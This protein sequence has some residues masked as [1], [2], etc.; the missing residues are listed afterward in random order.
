MSNAVGRPFQAVSTGLERPSSLAHF[1]A[2]TVKRSAKRVLRGRNGVLKTLGRLGPPGA[3]V[4]MYHSVQPD[5][6]AV[7][8]TIGEGISHAAAMFDRQMELIAREFTPVGLDAVACFLR[9]EESLPRR[10]VAVTFDD[11]FRDNWEIAAPILARHGI[12]ATFYITAGC[13]ES[14]KAPWFCRLRRAFRSGKLPACREAAHGQAGSLPYDAEQDMLAAMQRCATMTGGPQ[15]QWLASIESDCGVGPA[16]DLEGLMLDWDQVRALH[17]EGH[18][19]GSHT[20]SHANMAHV[21]LIEARRELQ[22]SKRLLESRLG[23]AV[24]HFSYPCP[25]LSPHWT[26]QTEALSRDVGYVTAATTDTGLVRAGCSA[27]LIPRIAAPM[28]M[29]EF[30]WALEVSLLGHRV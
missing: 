7:R 30:R 27:L 8:H 17:R 22:E 29:E 20:M 9:G 1:I 13:V 16:A 10:A 11:G 23:A 26:A 2:A 3:V 19:I 24:E 15:E 5:P 18:L 21:P 12:R 14:G 6:A 28:E 4:L 25:I